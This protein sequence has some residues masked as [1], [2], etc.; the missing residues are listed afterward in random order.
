MAQR[1]QSEDRKRIYWIVTYIDNPSY[2]ADR[3]WRVRHVNAA[4]PAMYCLTA[5]Q[6]AKGAE[7]LNEQTRAE[8][9]KAAQ[10]KMITPAVE[11]YLNADPGD[12]AELARRVVL[13]CYDKRRELTP[14]EHYELAC[15]VE[16]GD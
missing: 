12:K 13:E 16:N 10:I 4:Y 15:A 14:R 7:E 6:A 2:R 8:V 5:E 9:A 3:P 1:D 11:H